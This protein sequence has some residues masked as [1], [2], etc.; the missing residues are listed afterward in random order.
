MNQTLSAPFGGGAVS[1][2]KRLKQGHDP[3]G[4]AEA[5][6]GE[7]VERT[8]RI[9]RPQTVAVAGVEIR[10]EPRR[11]FNVVLGGEFTEDLAAVRIDDQPGPATVGPDLELS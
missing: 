7:E 6:A 11:G 3:G 2:R 8:P 4:R 1:L 5:V 10:Q 9:E